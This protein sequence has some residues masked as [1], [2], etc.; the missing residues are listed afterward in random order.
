PTDS[1]FAKLPKDVVDVAV[2]PLNRELLVDVLLTH[3]IGTVVSSSTLGQIP[4]LPSLSG[5]QLF[6]DKDSITVVDVQ[7]NTS[8]MVVAPFDTFATNGLIH[9][10]D[11][12][13]VLSQPPPSPAPTP[14]STPPPTMVPT[15]R[16]K[17]GKANSGKAKSGKANSGKAKSGKAKSG[18]VKSNKSK[19][20]K[21]EKGKKEKKL[22]RVRRRRHRLGTAVASRRRLII[23][24]TPARKR[25]RQAQELHGLPPRQV[26]RRGLPEGPPQEAQEG[27]QATRS[28]AQGRAA[29][30]AGGGL[31]PDPALCPFRFRWMSIPG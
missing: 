5:S 24:T 3:V 21:H 10:I 4:M 15:K 7:S 19:S 31:L 13:L 1:A 16:G 11:E 27:L 23:T 25:R 30:Q 12:V 2:D 8:G 17:S 14:E 29:V 28:R 18:K 22:Y 6:L 9:A 20:L 26:L